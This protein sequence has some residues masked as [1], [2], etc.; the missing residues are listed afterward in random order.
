MSAD[1]SERFIVVEQKLPTAYI[2][3]TTSPGDPL[4]KTIRWEVI[5]RGEEFVIW[6]TNC[7]F[8]A[9]AAFADKEDA[10]RLL[11]LLTRTKEL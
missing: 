11:R 9:I 2:I 6:K 1:P 3:T 10:L 7:K 8:D 5:D 4:V